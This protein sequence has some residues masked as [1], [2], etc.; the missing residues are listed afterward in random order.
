M[1]FVVPLFI[2][3]MRTSSMASEQAQVAN[4]LPRSA[5]LRPV[6]ESV[7]DHWHAELNHRLGNIYWLPVIFF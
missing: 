5:L 3:P 4:S 1:G 7:L 2:E 6:T